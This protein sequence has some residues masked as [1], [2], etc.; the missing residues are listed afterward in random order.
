MKKHHLSSTL[1]RVTHR[2]AIPKLDSPCRW[3]MAEGESAI[4]SAINIA[5]IFFELI[6]LKA[7]RMTVDDLLPCFTI[8]RYT[9]VCVKGRWKHIE[10]VVRRQYSLKT[11]TV[12]MPMVSRMSS[13]RA[14]HAV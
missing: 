9:W 11:S 4:D 13:M 8:H 3:F 7:K 6:E 2:G 1:A 5:T 10:D 14:A 12:N